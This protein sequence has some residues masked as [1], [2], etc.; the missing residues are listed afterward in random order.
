[1]IVI[2]FIVALFFVYGLLFSKTA[3]ESYLV[4]IGLVLLFL[5][6][7]YLQERGDSDSELAELLREFSLSQPEQQLGQSGQSGQTRQS[8][9]TEELVL[10]TA[11]ILA[12][13]RTAVIT[14]RLV[15]IAE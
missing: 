1:M 11:V 8:G 3:L 6:K 4:L 12:I 14:L 5:F 2:Q 13:F 9:Q 10:G 7:R 15:D